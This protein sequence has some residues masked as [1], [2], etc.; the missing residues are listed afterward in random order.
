MY[1]YTLLKI[2]RKKKK[3]KQRHLTQAGLFNNQTYKHIQSKS[4]YFAY[5]SNTHIK[6]T[7]LFYSPKHTICTST[8]T[9][10][11]RIS[12]INILAQA[13]RI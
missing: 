9:H 5:S 4:Q 1:L 6:K 11:L 12:H 10:S 8:H 13:K 3:N 2:K 7:T